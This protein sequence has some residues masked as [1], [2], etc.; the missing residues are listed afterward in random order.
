M[1]GLPNKENERLALEFLSAWSNSDADQLMAYF[2]EDAVYTDLPYP[3]RHGRAE[4]RTFIEFCFS[5]LRMD[6]EVHA[7]ASS[8]NLVFTERTEHVQFFEPPRNTDV[9]LAGVMTIENGLIVS[10]REYFDGRTAEGVN[11]TSSVIDSSTP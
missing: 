2:A 6:I 10:W 9:P 1:T 7:I 3:P 4:I 5:N 11:A 8:D